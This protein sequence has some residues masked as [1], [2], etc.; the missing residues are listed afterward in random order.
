MKSRVFVPQI[1]HRYD[2]ASGELFP[3]YDLSPAEEFG[4]VKVILT[5]SANPFTSMESIQA[6][7]REALADMTKD[8]YLLLV[9]NPAILGV[10]TAIAAEYTDGELQLL[11]WHGRE[12]RYNLIRA[13]I[14]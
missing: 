8:D 7:L 10:T 13:N 4:E 11:Q 5:P 9:G 3:V 14:N 1:P 6:D 12:K 2:R